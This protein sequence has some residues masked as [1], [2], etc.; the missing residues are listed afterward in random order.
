MTYQIKVR[1][2]IAKKKEATKSNTIGM[3]LD[4]MRVKMAAMEERPK[5]LRKTWL[6]SRWKRCNIQLSAGRAWE[7]LSA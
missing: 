5:A 3:V 2:Y 7:Q 6:Y 1:R 4:F